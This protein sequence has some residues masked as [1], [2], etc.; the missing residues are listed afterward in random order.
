MA[1]LLELAATHSGFDID[2][3][4]PAGWMGFGSTHAPLRV[5][6]HAGEVG[7]VMALS[8]RSVLGAFDT[9]ALG[10]PVTTTLPAGAVGARVVEDRPALQRALRRAWQLSRTLPNGLLHAFERRTQALPRSTEAERLVVQRVGQDLFRAGLLDYW[11]GR[12]AV[13][14]LGVRE[15][16]RASHIKPWAECETDA[17]RLDVFNGFLLEARIDAVFDQGFVTVADDGRLVV[18]AELG[19]EARELLGLDQERRV[20]WLDEQHRTYLAWHRARVFRGG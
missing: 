17:E 7:L 5:W 4:A 10:R 19:T 14:G 12:C 15:L 1:A 8:M 9:E 3:A 18:A 20:L 16:L 2:I 11:E 6:L 13:T